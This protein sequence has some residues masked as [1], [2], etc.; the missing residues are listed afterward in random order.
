M[1]RIG[2]AIVFLDIRPV[3][4]YGG[5]KDGTLALVDEGCAV[6]YAHL[7]DADVTAE[8]LRS[9]GE[10]V[11]LL[12]RRLPQIPDDLIYFADNLMRHPD[13]LPCASWRTPGELYRHN[14]ENYDG[15]NS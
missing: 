5:H 4:F 9:A 3:R 12:A 15:R 1:G 8:H 11:G 7:Y 6:L 2:Y 13:F 14:M 10:H